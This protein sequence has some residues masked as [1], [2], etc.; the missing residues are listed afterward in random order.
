MPS[1]LLALQFLTVLPVKIASVDNTRLARSLIFYPV[2]GLMLGSALGGFHG[3]LAFSS[4]G[5]WV[6]AVI[7]T[8]ALAAI[9]GGL[10][11]DGLADTADALLSGKSRADKL[12]IMRDP[13]VGVMGAIALM[14]VLLLKSSL[15]A[16]IGPGDSI[17]SFILMCVNSRWVMVMSLYIAPYAREDGKA[18][19]F[20]AGI[21][22]KIFVV[23][24][25]IAAVCSFSALAYA[26]LAVMA[27]AGAFAYCLTFIFRR[28][29]GGITGD[30]LGA[31]CE[32]AEI[33]SLVVL[34][35]LN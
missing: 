24:T 32:L 21:D 26:G 25:L 12:K 2:I 31:E 7:V 34:I 8:I 1:F 5:P 20:S 10:H 9:T 6:S 14:S 4:L 35:C 13:H 23:A 29:L 18:K 17:R 22:A 11:L 27:A 16:M 28:S 3:L 33:V 19:L 30:T 15:I